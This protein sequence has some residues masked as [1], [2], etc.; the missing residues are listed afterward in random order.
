VDQQREAV[1]V[2]TEGL[3]RDQLAQRHLPS[4]LTLGGLLNHLALVED[5]WLPGRFLGLPE[6]EPWAGVDWDTDPNREFRAA[7]AESRDE[8]GSFFDGLGTVVVGPD[9]SCTATA[10]CAHDRCTSFAQGSSDSTPRTSG[11]PR[12]DGHATVHVPSVPARRGCRLPSLTSR[13]RCPVVSSSA[14]GKAPHQS[15]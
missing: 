5:S 10:T 1:L 11:R 7:A 9:C 8:V 15:P 6:R 12:N 3:A 14:C 13:R 4:T 2:K